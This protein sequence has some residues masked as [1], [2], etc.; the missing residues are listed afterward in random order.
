MQYAAVRDPLS[1]L[2]NLSSQG[3]TY[4][5][6]LQAPFMSGLTWGYC[7]PN[8]V[9][10]GAVTVGSYDS[11]TT[12]MQQYINLVALTSVWEGYGGQ[13]EYFTPFSYVIASDKLV[14]QR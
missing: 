9:G 12:S 4:I 7:Y 6:Q 11:S 5:G 1:N 3:L 8:W 2:A 10:V 14:H 13:E